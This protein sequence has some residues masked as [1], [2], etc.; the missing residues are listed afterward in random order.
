MKNAAHMAGDSAIKPRSRSGARDRLGLQSRPST[1]ARGAA[2][3]LRLVTPRPSQAAALG[4]I[5]RLSADGEDPLRS[6]CIDL[7][8]RLRSREAEIGEAV[9]AH[10]R[11][12]DPDAVAGGH[13]HLVW[14]LREMIAAC[15][16]HGLASIEH[17][18]QYPVSVP[19]AVSAQARRTASSGVSLTTALSLC[20]ASY[21]LAW[22]VV[23]NEVADHDLPGEQGFA[24]L[25]QA[26]AVMGALL[27]RVQAEIAS[28][29]SSE[30]TRRARSHEQRRTEIVHKLLVEESVDGGAL[31]EL[32]YRLDAWHLGV[33][34]TGAG[35]GRAVRGL[36]AKLGC[37]LLSV[38]RGG[39]TVWAWLGGQ[40]RPAFADA[41]RVLSA[42]EYVDVSFAIGEPA[43][44]AEG[45]RHTHREAADALLVARYRPRKLTRYL[46]VAPDATALRD[47]A[48]ADSLIET[49]LSPLDRM[50]IGGRAARRTLR[51]LLDTGHNAS[52]AASAL[53]VDRSTVH[54]RRNEIEQRLGCRLHERQVEIEVALRVEDLRERRAID[55]A[56]AG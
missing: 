49:Y 27:A 17:G 33:I 36:S 24:L 3:L 25:H 38:P 29:H 40:R 23:L 45:W 20:V 53:R 13:A 18:A 5:D 54:R 37:E 46:D 7:A 26:S 43:R 12:A 50:R 11:S 28:A 48:L 32:G 35:A 52:S 4:K 16:D 44:G 6:A 15:V 34:A 42:G 31:A 9:L 41:E 47:E 55:N 39:E 19:P 2:G 8:R 1:Q 14:G 10:V 51:A 22:S 56:G 21:T 30:I